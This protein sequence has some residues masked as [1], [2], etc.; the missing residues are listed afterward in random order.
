MTTIT[1][2]IDWL[3][4]TNTPEKAVITVGWRCTG[5][6]DTFTASVYSTCSLPEADPTNFIAYDELTKEQV[7]AWVYAN[8]VNKEATEAAVAA[9]IEAQKNPVTVQPQLPW[10]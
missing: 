1:W 4:A 10:L 5:V 2:T 3:S 7:L 9:Q 8:G 6:E